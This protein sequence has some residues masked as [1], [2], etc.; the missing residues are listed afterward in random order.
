MVV[1]VEVV[2]VVVVAVVVVEVVVLVMLPE[3]RSNT[4]HCWPYR[5][6]A[7]ANENDDNES[8]HVVSHE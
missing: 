8:A 1:V 4:S 5:V 7:M 2:V 6:R 3:I